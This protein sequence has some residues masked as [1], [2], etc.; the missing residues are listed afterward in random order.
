MDPV[1]PHYLAG[2]RG[3]LDPLFESAPA[4]DYDPARD[5]IVVLSDHHRGIG[6]G[7]D[8]FRRC[9]RAYTAALGFYLES[10]YRLLLLGD[11]EE[12]WETTK[13]A[14]IFRRYEDVLALERAF[15]QR[16]RL[17]RFWGNHDDR[18]AHPDAVRKELRPI[19]GQAPMYEALRLRV[20]RP[21]G[22]PATI[23]LVHGHQGTPESDRFS[24][25][26]RLPVR[27]LWTWIQRW[28]G[29]SA[30]TPAQDHALRAKHDT[31]MFEW[32]RERPNR[33]LVAGHT[34]RPVFAGSKP[35]PPPVRPI[36]EIEAA[37]AKAREQGDG[38]GAALAA[39]E[40]EYAR[41]LQRRP[42]TAVTVSPPCYFNT[43][44]CSF[45]DGDITGIEIAD[46]EIR[47]VRWPANIDE[48]RQDGSGELD[49]EKRIL[50]HARERLDAI[51]DLVAEP[52]AVGAIEEHALT[53][54]ESGGQAV[55][56]LG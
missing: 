44:C 17:V 37:V 24:A 9:E 46:G 13:P 47:L 56:R 16:G 4:E 23:F 12:L 41:T 20:E 6:D 10:G 52:P 11:T 34:H 28:Q 8:D 21:A 29:F 2:I 42:Q 27:F 25:L 33:V 35:D 49:A 5:Q 39:A 3:R 36:P 1:D 54:Q 30:T 18:W 38:Q 43:G 48:L 7:A 50:P 55:P 15:A 51:L 19:I 32:A 53:G 14:K 45:P 22:D 40:L 26:A 31:A